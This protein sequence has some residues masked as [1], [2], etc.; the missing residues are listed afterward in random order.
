MPISYKND[1]V[2]GRHLPIERTGVID[3][4]DLSTLAERANY[5]TL[6]RVIHSSFLRLKTF[7]GSV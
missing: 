2:S 7:H 1:E 6:E 4:L 5:P 3:K